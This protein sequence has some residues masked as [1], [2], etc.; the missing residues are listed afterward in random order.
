[1]KKLSLFLLVATLAF[2]GC[3]D[4]DNDTDNVKTYVLSL[5]NYEAET[6]YYGN[7]ESPAE[8]WESYG[9]PYYWTYLHDTTN[10]FEFDCISSSY[11][12]GMDAFG[13]TNRTS[14]DYSAITK[15]GVKNNTYIIV[16]A[17]G[18]GTG[19]NYDKDVAIRFKNNNT[20]DIKTYQVKGLFLTNTV[21]AYNSMKNGSDY[22]H[23]RGEEDKFGNSDSFKVIIYNLDKTQKVECYLAEGTSLLTEWKWVDLTSLGK[24]EGLK[25][26]L[27][28]TKTND[29]GAM[30]PTYFCLDGITVED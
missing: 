2:F 16:G 3:S 7:T 21:Y 26:E 18:Y 5:P 1:M 23:E 29:G 25:F 13:F 24:T 9:T 10:I 27:V 28:T 19:P 15:K 4:D 20:N 8:K 14:G 11:G 17:S 6:D 22:F 30:T 12:I